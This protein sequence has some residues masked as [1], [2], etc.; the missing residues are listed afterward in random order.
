M[1]IEVKQIGK[2]KDKDP[3]SEYGEYTM[4]PSSARSYVLSR[5]LNGKFRT[6]LEDKEERRKHLEALLNKDL[7]PT[8]DFWGTL[9][10]TF[11]MPTGTQK[12]D[13][14]NP[15]D[16]ITVYAAIAN[17]LLAPDRDTLREDMNYKQN[18]IFYIHDEE[19]QLKRQSALEEIK[20]EVTSILYSIRNNKEKML[21]I[22]HSLGLFVTD[23]FRTDNLY[24]T[25][26]KYK[27]RLLSL[28]HYEKFRS[29]LK[30]PNEELQVS[31]YVKH[32]LKLSII[33]FDSNVNKYKFQEKH[34]GRVE[35]DI[36]SFF[37]EKKHEADLAALIMEVKD[38]EN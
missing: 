20:G 32:G 13:T 15:R 34:V 3:K 11:S 27:D 6:G 30:T 7:S 2:F 1:I 24:S 23:S 4:F 37:K 25:L 17:H 19:A 33:V 16:E 28:E 10:I 35:A 9:R 12:F 22:A 29:V 38:R 18:T 26:N 5:Q 36:Q 21:F 31:Y 8:S 14:T